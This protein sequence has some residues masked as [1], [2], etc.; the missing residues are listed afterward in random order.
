MSDVAI[1]MTT[2]FPA[3]DVGLQRVHAATTATK[4]W[5]ARLSGA[6]VRLHIADDASHQGWLDKFR[7]PF[8]N[9]SMTSTPR[10]GTGGALNAGLRY[11]FEHDLAPVV[12]YVADDWELTEPLDLAP[13]LALLRDGVADVVR[14]G[15]THPSLTGHVVRTA[16]PGAEWC[17]EYDWMGGGYVFGHRPALHHRRLYDQHGYYIEG[18]AAIEVER[19]YNARLA[20]SATP[21]RVFHAPNCTLAGPFRHIDTVELGE[22]PPDVLT[23]RY[24][25]GTP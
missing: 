12:A 23:A 11:V 17:L 10:L 8:P 16:S 7:R 18:A 15:P 6:T 19:E 20:L 25:N 4:S 21:P 24:A 3:G 22:D 14:L 9:A 2:W 13:S 5:L 1:V